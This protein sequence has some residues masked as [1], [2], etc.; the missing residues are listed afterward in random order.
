MDLNQQSSC[1][2]RQVS[3]LTYRCLKLISLP[4]R[5]TYTFF[6]KD[7]INNIIQYIANK[8]EK[9][10]LSQ[11]RKKSDSNTQ[12]FNTQYLVNILPYQWLFFLYF[13]VCRIWTYILMIKSHMHYHYTKTPL[14]F[15]SKKIFFTNYLNSKLQYIRIIILRPQNVS[16]KYHLQILHDGDL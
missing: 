3:Q 6:K 2:K 12:A 14:F 5:I 11:N 1:G 4:L 16:I 15:K 13:R 7:I 9:S 8:N 10:S